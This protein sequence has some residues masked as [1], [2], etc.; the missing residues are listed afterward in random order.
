MMSLWR[1]LSA[2]FLKLR[3][4]LALRL[5]VGAPLLVVLLNFG[6]AIQRPGAPS[7]IDPF[8]GFAQ[9]ILTLWTLIVLPFYAALAAA[10]M[11]SIEFQGDNWRHI[12]SLPIERRSIFLAKWIAG[13]G[14]LLISS[15]VLATGICVS[16]G[17][18]RLVAPAWR[19]LAVPVGKAFRGGILSWSAVTLL[20]SIQMWISLRW[21]S[22]VLGLGFG[23]AAILLDLVGLGRSGVSQFYPWAMPVWTIALN[24]SKPFLGFIGLMGA[25]GVTA[26]ACS[27]L[28][29]REYE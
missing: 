1:A 18:L 2:E 7:S 28:S 21:R 10:L 13:V 24:G 15:I 5:A 20:F 9:G 4:T 16:T 6:V 22:F 3:R 29:R 25:V 23:I 19:G 12:L 26:L 11:A 14:L 17:I 27:N 8:V